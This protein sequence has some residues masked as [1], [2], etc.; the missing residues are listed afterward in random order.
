[1][2]M[3]DQSINGQQE[4]HPELSTY[5]KTPLTGIVLEQEQT[6]LTYEH[7]AKRPTTITETGLSAQLLTQL[8]IKHILFR[9]NAF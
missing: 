6:N 2:I 9:S 7:L 4:N 3:T 8:L 1:M 5:D